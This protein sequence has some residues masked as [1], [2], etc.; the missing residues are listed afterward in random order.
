MA[1]L[2]GISVITAK[3]IVKYRKDIKG[4][5]SIEEFYEFLNLKQHFRDILT[6]RIEIKKIVLPKKIKLFKE[7]KIDL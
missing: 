6:D 1:D 7:R 2:P 5:K 3:R 4:F